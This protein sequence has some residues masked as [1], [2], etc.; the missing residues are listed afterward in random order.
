MNQKLIPIILD[1]SSLK[2]AMTTLEEA[3]SAHQHNTQ[4][5]FITDACIQRFE[6]TYELAHKTIRRYLE[7]NEPTSISVKD[8]SFQALIRLAY[9]R[10]LLNLELIHWKEFREARNLTSHTYDENKA[11]DIFKIIPKFLAEAKFL[12]DAIQKRQQDEIS[13]STF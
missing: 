1:L 12:H 8:L 3:L 5:S 10:S 11:K 6:Y 7:M 9:E 2:K 13:D 4:N